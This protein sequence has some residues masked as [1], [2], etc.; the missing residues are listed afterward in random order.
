[1][2]RSIAVCRLAAVA[3]VFGLLAASPMASAQT[4]GSKAVNPTAE[5]V[6]EEQLLKELQ[7]VQGRV[8]IPDQRSNVLIQPA[9]RDWRQFRQN[10]LPLIGAVAIVG[11][12][13]LLLLFLAVRGRVRIAQGFSG[14]TI[15]RFNATE[16]FAHWLTAS[17]FVVLALTGLNVTFG[18]DY[19]LPV[20]G[21]ETFT[22]LSQW[23]KYLHN[24]MSFAFVL[25]LVM[26]F[27]LWVIHNVPTGR[28]VRWIAEGGG[29][30]GDKH[31]P[32]GRF[33]AGQKLVFWT[34]VLGGAALAI[35]GY[36]LMFPF[37]SLPSSTLTAYNTS[38]DAIQT[39]QV[40]HGIV[41]LVMIAVILGHIYIGTVGMQGAFSSMGSGQVDVNWARQHH[42]IW[43]EKELGRQ[44]SGSTMPAE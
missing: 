4:A 42:S 15:E 29:I 5:S 27:L 22:L 16:R 39:A 23:A 21:A 25:G 19:L 8:S 28:G 20:V 1:M 13:A 38:I 6:K 41:G 17:S 44:G 2:S 35:T 11:A 40:I 7:R 9:G 30:V 32:A 37:Y 10:T 18:R 24:Y 14:Q 43:A 33:N 31:P 34:V 26:I 36:M 3:F 12:A